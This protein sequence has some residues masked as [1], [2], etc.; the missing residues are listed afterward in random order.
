MLGASSVAFL[1]RPLTRG[2]WLLLVLDSMKVGQG[3]PRSPNYHAA[4]EDSFIV[5]AFGLW[6]PVRQGPTYTPHAPGNKLA[7]DAFDSLRNAVNEHH[8]EGQGIPP[9]KESRFIDPSQ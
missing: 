9:R 3:F 7:A 5:I 8:N 2:V 6:P 4:I 1:R